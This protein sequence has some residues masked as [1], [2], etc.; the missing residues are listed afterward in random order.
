MKN[1]NIW[2]HIREKISS[3]LHKYSSIV[4]LAEFF[5]LDLATNLGEGK[6][7]LNQLYPDWKQLCV[8]GWVNIY[9]VPVAKN[10]P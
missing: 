8:R 5:S 3:L 10:D 2:N 7:N 1:K 4:E 9:I 6:L